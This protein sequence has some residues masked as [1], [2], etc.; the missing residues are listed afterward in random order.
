MKSRGFTLIEIVVAMAILGVGL[1]VI[2]ELFA[3]G[4]RLGRASEE[5]TKAAGYA[6]M[7]LEEFAMTEL[8]G[9]GIQQ[10][11]FDPEYRWQMEAR[12]INVLPIEK[13]TDFKPAVEL[14]QIRFSVLW[15]SGMKER[16]TVFQSY[17]TV[18]LPAD[19]RKG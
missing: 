13:T 16:S 7:K 14:Y 9:E 3:G 6:R 17:K 10:G 15:R 19:E 12:K 11:Q 1:V 8:I 5:Y 2:I 4:L 18:K